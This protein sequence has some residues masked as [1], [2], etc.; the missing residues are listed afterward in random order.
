M[1]SPPHFVTEVGGVREDQSLAAGLAFESRQVCSE[2]C[3]IGAPGTGA[4]KQP[5][6][7]KVSSSPGL[8]T[9]NVQIVYTDLLAFLDRPDIKGLNKLLFMGLIIDDL[10][11]LPVCSKDNVVVVESVDAVGH[12]AV[13][14]KS[15]RFINTLSLLPINTIYLDYSK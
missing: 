14:D 3:D 10:I 4:V 15:Q 8:T 5:G 12:A 13:V 11:V 1:T 2:L 6:V 9:P 7:A